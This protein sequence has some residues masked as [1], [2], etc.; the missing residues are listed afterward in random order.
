[1][2]WRKLNRD[3]YQRIEQAHDKLGHPFGFNPLVL[4]S[5]DSFEA[6]PRLM[7][8]T[9]N[10]AGDR[11]YP[12]HRGV[13]RYEGGNAY[14]SIDWGGHGKGKAPLQRQVQGVFRHLQKRAGFAGPLDEFARSQVV[15][16][17]IVPFRSP[18]EKTLH[19]RD[20]SLTFSRNLWRE[21]FEFWRPEAVVS[22]S[23]TTTAEL[24]GLLGDIVEESSLPTG[25]GNYKM[26]LRGFEGG[27]RLLGLP[28]LSRFA[29]FGRW[30]SEPHLEEAFD[31]LLPS[32]ANGGAT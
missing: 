23:G 28:H 11:D 18:S 30:Q 21:I 12:S 9:L 10:P 31:W 24:T 26:T 14:T 19:R 22:I 1:M 17:Q 29:L 32:D 16:S 15:T 7:V 8:S 5:V 20:E 25:W 4:S 13:E 27:T 2:N 3:W 6:S